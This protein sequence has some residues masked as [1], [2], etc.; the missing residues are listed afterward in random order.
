MVLFYNL[1]LKFWKMSYLFWLSFSSV[2]TL[3][4]SKGFTKQ[5]MFHLRLREYT[6]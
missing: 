4:S 1:Q 2:F 6:F 3:H 5:C